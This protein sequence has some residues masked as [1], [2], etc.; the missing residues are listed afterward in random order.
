M[1]DRAWILLQGLRQLSVRT[2]SVGN[3]DDGIGGDRKLIVE[4]AEK[5]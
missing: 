3:Y 2:E 4:N 5:E 1:L